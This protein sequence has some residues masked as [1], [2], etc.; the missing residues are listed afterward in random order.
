[1]AFK[2]SKI[3]PLRAG[4]RIIIFS[5][6]KNRSRGCNMYMTANSTVQM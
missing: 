5:I 2:Y 6:F 1:M 4:I 3:S